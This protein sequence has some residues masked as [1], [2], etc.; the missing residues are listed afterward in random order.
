MLIVANACGLRGGVGGTP[1][2]WHS[3]GSLEVN[4]ER[5][6]GISG[7]INNFKTNNCRLMR[8]YCRRKGGGQEDHHRQ[9]PSEAN[10]G[11]DFWHCCNFHLRSGGEDNRES[12]LLQTLP[13]PPQQAWTPISTVG[14]V[15]WTKE[16]LRYQKSLLTAPRVS[17]AATFS[18]TSR[19]P[20]RSL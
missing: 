20:P 12:L 8:V 11:G 14:L 18:D 19:V 6:K 3:Q 7:C 15:E 1:L 2:P 10:R 16:T 5:E 13:P 9:N 17:L 4:I